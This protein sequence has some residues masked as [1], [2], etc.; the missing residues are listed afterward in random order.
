MNYYGYTQEELD[1]I[2]KIVKVKVPHPSEQ[3]K[4]SGK[5]NPNS[6]YFQKIKEVSY[7]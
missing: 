5:L 3:V 7:R 4:I 2:S 6:K 1:Y